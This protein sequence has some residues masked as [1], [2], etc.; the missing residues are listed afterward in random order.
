MRIP[1]TAREIA[2]A[3]G[4]KLLQ[5]GDTARRVSTDSRDILTGDLFVPLVGERFDGHAYIDMALQKGAAGCL[6]AQM[7]EVLLPGKFYIAVDDTEAALGRLAAWYRG[8][9]D[10]PHGAGHRLRGQNHHQGDAGGGAEPALSYP[11]D[12]GKL[13]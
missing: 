9:F 12:P 8:K 3:V 1:C 11:Q 5:D 7:P 2:A 6:C 13:Q 4:G 10:H